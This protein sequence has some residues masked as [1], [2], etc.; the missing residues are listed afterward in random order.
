M[1]KNK[2]KCLIA[3]AS[4]LI[5]KGL[6]K[7]LCPEWDVYAFSRR[8]PAGV[9]RRD[10]NWL[11][12]DLAG[13]WD[14]K[15]LPKK[16]DAVIYL[17]QSDHFRDFPRY[18]PDIFNVNVVG[19]FRMLEY[20][21]AAGSRTFILASS[22]GIET[23]GGKSACPRRGDD[24][25][26]HL[27]TKLCAEILARQYEQFFNVMILRFFFVY[28]KG[29]RRDMLV[30]RLA[31]SVRAGRPII[32]AGRNGI[33]INPTYISDAAGTIKSA[34]KLKK[35]IKADI[36]GPKAYTLREIGNI[37]GKEVGRKPVFKIGNTVKPEHIIG[38]I[39]EMSRVLGPPKVSF[40]EGIALFLRGKG[41]DE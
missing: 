8:R 2:K 10:I 34:L 26:F 1:A 3:G 17:A 40:E 18:A 29:Q 24:I 31:G 25:S 11:K 9:D 27:K 28:G 37:I 36:A 33:K 39:A 20:A 6:I 14:I 12:V 22:G 23:N 30:P 7:E 41:R 4:G 15:A 5:G 32:L 13:R 38:D 21:K 16:I 35:S 19:V